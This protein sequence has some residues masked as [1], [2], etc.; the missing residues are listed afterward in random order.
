MKKLMVA[1]TTTA[2]LAFGLTTARA[3]PDQVKYDDTVSLFKHAGQSAAFFHHS[4]AYAV[5]PTVGEGA[6]VVGG[7]GGKGGVFLGGQQVGTAT[8]AQVSVGFQ[9]GGKAF[10]EIIFFEDQRAL[11]EFETGN[12]EFG[13]DA[14]VVAVTAGADAGAGT[15]G[16]QA[17]ASGGEKDART[18][19]H[20][21]KGMAVFTIA[22][23]GLM[24]Q[25]AVAG[26]KFSYK[27][28]AA[29]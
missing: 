16:A 6:F 8:L 1:L 9:A 5:F 15:N 27:P 24:Y 20:Y 23:G 29:S 7:A 25:A 3:E 2:A 4:Y 14:S 13:A 21:Y 10:S 22:K 17:G 26:Q 19:G 18:H 28:F 11:N 12:F